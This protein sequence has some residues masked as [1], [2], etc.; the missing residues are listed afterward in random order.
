MLGHWDPFLNQDFDSF[1]LNLYESFLN[2]ISNFTR[3]V[4]E[5]R[6]FFHNF[7]TKG[8]I[9]MIRYVRVDQEKQV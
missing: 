7:F 4:L 6:N 1:F 2:R 3:N 9:Q 8:N 5:I